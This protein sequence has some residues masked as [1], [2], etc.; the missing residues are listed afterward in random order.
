MQDASIGSTG[1][2]RLLCCVYRVP[3]VPRVCGAG[4]R[5][6]GCNRV[7][8]SADSQFA[9]LQCPCSPTFWSASTISLVET[10]ARF[11]D[12]ASLLMI[13]R[14]QL[15]RRADGRAAAPVFVPA[16]PDEVAEAA[17]SF[18]ADGVKLS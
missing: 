10:C 14:S 8:A 17:I 11:P 15:R 18:A 5:M 4:F 13:S 1:V 3:R 16:L 9:T 6:E 2:R 7:S 12:R